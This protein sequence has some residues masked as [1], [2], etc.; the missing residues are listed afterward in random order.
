M[1]IGTITIAGDFIQ[2]QGTV[3]SYHNFKPGSTHKVI[4]NG[5]EP[6]VVKF[7]DPDNWFGVLEVQ[8]S[9]SIIA[10]GY[11]NVNTLTVSVL[12][13]VMHLS[14]LFVSL[15]LSLLLPAKLQK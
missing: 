3:S 15:F 12:S 10:E 1:S 2:K 14:K 4:L 9:S 5:T 13:A 11:F 8:N 7:S 6:Q